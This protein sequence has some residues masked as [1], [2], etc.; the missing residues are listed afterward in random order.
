MD[1]KVDDDEIKLISITFAH[2]CRRASDR[3]LKDAM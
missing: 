2:I 3:L 1:R